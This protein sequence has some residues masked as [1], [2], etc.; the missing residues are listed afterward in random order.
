M[1]PDAPP[2]RILLIE[3]D[4][5]LVRVMAWALRDEGF[6]VQVLS[7]REALEEHE[8]EGPDVAIFNMS[9]NA[10]DKTLY[11]QQLRMLNPDCV[12][13]DVDEFIAGG[14]SIRDSGADAYTDRPLQMDAAL[15]KIIRELTELSIQGR[16]DRRDERERDYRGS[17]DDAQ[18]AN[19]PPEDADRR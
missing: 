16:E 13:V 18:G 5:P 14:G 19:R 7:K 17:A 11:I 8:L 4:A 3:D 6:D 12:I 15:V 2:L 10:P 1:S 9:A